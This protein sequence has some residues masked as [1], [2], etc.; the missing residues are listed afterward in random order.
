MP[1]ARCVLPHHTSSFPTE[2]PAA[3]PRPSP[4][5][6]I[7]TPRRPLDDPRFLEHRVPGLEAARCAAEIGQILRTLGSNI[8]SS[9]PCAPTTVSSAILSPRADANQVREIA[10]R[11]HP[12]S[13]EPQGKRE[14]IHSELSERMP[15]RNSRPGYGSVPPP[16]LATA[17]LTPWCR[18]QGDGPAQARLPGNGWPRYVLGF[19]PCPRGHVFAKIPSETSWVS[20]GCPELP[21]RYRR[22]HDGNKPVE[23]SG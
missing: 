10:V 21:S 7:T 14:G 5:S 16:P 17:M 13:A 2:P 23:E 8:H 18:R 4:I 11:P 12:R 6:T 19:V 9:Q 20:R 3:E 22:S 15:L 1:P